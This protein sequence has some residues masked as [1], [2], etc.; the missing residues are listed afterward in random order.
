MGDAI[1]R[2]YSRCQQHRKANRGMLSEA[3]ARQIAE[4]LGIPS[5][6]VPK[7]WDED[8][9]DSVPIGGS[10]ELSDAWVGAQ[11]RYRD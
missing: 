1:D 2:F 6:R 4:G 7:V 8:D 11:R 10:S 9:E 5:N 3:T